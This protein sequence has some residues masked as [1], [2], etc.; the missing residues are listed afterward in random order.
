MAA[1]DLIR[2]VVDLWYG[3][4]F[5]DV[6]W[7]SALRA[8]SELL[9][10]GAAAVLDV[11]RRNARVGRIFVHQLYNSDEYVERMSKIN[12][13]S[14]YSLKLPH[15][16]VFT[17]Y[18][19]MTERAIDRDEFYD[20]I[21]RSHGLRY[22]VGARV[23]DDGPRS[24]CA[25]VEFTRRH[26]HADQATIERF[27]LITPHIANA[28][29]ISGLI[30]K[31]D[32][33]KNLIEM[34]AGQ[35]LCGTVGLR[36]DGSVLF[37]NAAAAN[38]IRS[39][40]GLAVNDGHLRAARAANDRTLQATIARVLQPPNGATP[41]AGGALA[42]SR[43]SGRVPF[44]LRV[45]PTGANSFGQD[46]LPAALV[47]IADPD[48]RGIPREETLRS[49]GFSA[50]ESRLAQRLVQGRTLVQAASDLH[51]AHNTARAHLRNIF[52][53]TRA[54]SQVELVRMLCEFARL[55]G[56]E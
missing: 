42:V 36:A 14:I 5:G 46:D 7:A 13:R 50:S 34:L 33:A 16:H 32:N 20:W 18:T 28:W 25:S 49:L 30:E 21:G 44:I 55:D 37:M 6:P 23:F 40:D 15:P 9:G 4:G 1:E 41:D 45:T 52:A 56:A 10:G 43:P 8:T 31:V 47:L 29:R 51:M 22:F 3:A 27:K 38:V 2:E 17:D 26:G 11:D 12:P 19:V 39:A 35:R 48:R 54:R 53:K 24:L